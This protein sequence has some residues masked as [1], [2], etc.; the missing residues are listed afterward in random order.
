MAAADP[1]IRQQNRKLIIKLAAVLVVMFGFAFALVPL[2]DLICD[3]TGLN[4]KT[5]T[6]AAQ[7]TG[8]VDQSR[9]IKVQFMATTSN[10]MPWDFKPVQ[11]MVE[12]TPGQSIEVQFFAKN[13]SANT[14]VGQAIPSL[15]PNVAAPHFKK[16]EC[17]CFQ[18]QE[19]QASEQTHMGLVFYV[20]P[21]LPENINTLTLAY[22]L[23]NITDQVARAEP[24]SDAQ[25]G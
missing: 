23:Y 17:F 16:I 21:D 11:K 24:K 13:N 1:N 4:G 8:D 3:V 9:M 18:Q 7:Q 5:N 25:Q 10:G 2:Y 14:I 15:S 22:T 19:L 12:V 6:S 20:S